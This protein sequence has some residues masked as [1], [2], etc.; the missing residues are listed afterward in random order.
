MSFSDNVLLTWY[1]FIILVC[2]CISKQLPVISKMRRSECFSCQS[3]AKMVLPNPKLHSVTPL[4]W[5]FTTD[6]SYVFSC[7]GLSVCVFVLQKLLD[8]FLSAVQNIRQYVNPELEKSKRCNI[9]YCCINLKTSWVFVNI[10]LLWHLMAATCLN[11]LGQRQ[12]NACFGMPWNTC[13][14]LFTGLHW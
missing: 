10:C 1:L 11:K 6:Y 2:F 7:V 4:A 3:S 5:L 12:Q 14:D 8:G 9:L 13:L